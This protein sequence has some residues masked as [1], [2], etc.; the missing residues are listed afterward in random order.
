MQWKSK[1]V[2]IP[3]HQQVFFLLPSSG[4]SNAI[5][6]E[7]FY[8]VECS[9]IEMLYSDLILNYLVNGSQNFSV[10]CFLLGY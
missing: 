2:T 9:Y 1:E 3:K 7:V 6:A 10:R 5:F 4:L 8:D